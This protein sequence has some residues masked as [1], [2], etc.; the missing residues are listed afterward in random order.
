MIINVAGRARRP[1]PA[2]Q[3]P[4]TPTF[5]P[6]AALSSP[7]VDGT[8][9]S[10]GEN[11]G[12]RD[13]VTG[14]LLLFRWTSGNSNIALYSSQNEGA[15][16]SL[17]ASDV[18]NPEGGRTIQYPNV[19]FSVCQ[20]AAGKVHGIS[21]GKQGNTN[22]Y[23]CRFAL[24]R[25]GG[26]VTGFS[27]ERAPVVMGTN[28]G[29]T[30]FEI[31]GNIYVMKLDGA[32]VLTWTYGINQAGGLLDCNFYGGRSTTLTPNSSA[33][34]VQFNGS[35]GDNLLF[36]DTGNDNKNHDMEGMLCQNEASEDI[37]FVFGH[38]NADM[39]LGGSGAKYDIKA[40]RLPK[41]S[42]GFSTASLTPVTIV[43][44]GAVIPHLLDSDSTTDKAWVM[45]NHPSLG[46]NFGYFDSG[47]TWHGEAVTSPLNTANR[48]AFGTFTAGNDGRLWAVFTSYGV[49]N[50][51]NPNS[52]GRLAYWNGASW[53]TQN[54]ATAA[55]CVTIAGVAYWGSQA[56]GCLAMRIDG[57]CVAQTVSGIS[58]AAVYGP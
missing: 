49:Y 5:V 34:F 51:G 21:T 45:Y 25:S 28:H 4:A 48:A 50:S 46:I 19:L 36:A 13:N 17:L 15:T 55:N 40:I 16:W 2:A 39:A 54:D 8:E 42:G 9:W 24:T 58:L 27:F 37:Y 30:G 18:S 20:D 43:A 57:D 41:I 14:D 38:I 26:H 32:E 29:R 22:Y 11:K 12:I 33:D 6:F 53:T 1:P 44:N 47:G 52:V 23:Y 10:S 56:L 31:R 7:I 35:A 3:N